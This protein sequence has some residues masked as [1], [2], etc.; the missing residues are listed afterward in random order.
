MTARSSRRAS[1]QA[2][3]A[4]GSLQRQP[5]EEDGPRQQPGQLAGVEKSLEVLLPREAG[6]RERREGPGGEARGPAA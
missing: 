5:D 3:S 6:E 4:I 1:T 2:T